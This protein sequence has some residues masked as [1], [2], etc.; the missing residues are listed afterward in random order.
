MASVH[1]RKGTKNWFALFLLPGGKR[2]FR[3]TGLEDKAAAQRLADE[4][5]RLA[6]GPV[7]GSLD[8]ARRVTAE[9]VDG[10]MGSVGVARITCRQYVERWLEGLK[11]TVADSTLAFYRGA[12]VAWLKWL[13]ERADEPLDS[14]QHE[15]VVA[16][17]LAELGRVRAK[18]ASQRTKALRAMFA[19]AKALGFVHR[20]PTAGL[21]ALRVRPV[22]R[23]E[24]ARR[25]F[26]RKELAR[27]LASAEGDWA[28]VVRLGLET[29]QRLGDLV[30]MDWRDVDGD[31]G[32]WTVRTS[33]KGRRLVLPLSAGVL[34]A[35]KERAASAVGT[36][37]F[38]TMVSQLTA[39]GGVGT[40]SNQFSMLLWQLGLRQYSPHDRIAKGGKKAELV[41]A[42][43]D[44][45]EQQEL[46]FHSLRHTARTWLEE[47]GQPKA[48]ID[49][50]IG[51][52]GD[53][54]KIYTTVGLD[55]LRAAAAV[56]GAVKS[57]ASGGENVAAS[58]NE[59][60]PQ[61]TETGQG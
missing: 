6:R 10:L 5:E 3:S 22:D 17:R 44:R 12:L 35:L 53:T 57:V 15:D 30:R 4:W 48:V 19:E 58:E 2:F 23:E 43:A 52:S 51:H 38:P 41:A 50:L 46:S 49:A 61:T 7:P 26:T 24:R 36:A 29:G 40:L 55:A 18:T 39:A 13:G 9:L 27:V 14:I 31:A 37:V 34:A 25:P 28:L 33:K 54:G 11:G 56:L 20:D 8:Q 47:A 42:G 59:G 45:R 16:W 1:R 32:L 21:R 60:N